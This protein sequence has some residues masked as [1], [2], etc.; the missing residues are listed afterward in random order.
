[1]TQCYLVGGA[2]RDLLLGK[3]PKDFDFAVEASSYEAMRNWLLESGFEI[4]LEAP[5]YFTIRARHSGPWIFADMNLSTHTFDFVLCRREN[6]YSD[7]RHPDSV[8]VGTIYDDLAR[9]D[10]TMNAM[11]IAENGQFIDPYDGKDD[12]EEKLIR[13][14]GD[15][16]R[17]IEDALR[18]FRVI[19]F[20]VVLSFDI[21]DPILDLIESGYPIQFMDNVSVERIREELNKAFTYSSYATLLQLERFSHLQKWVFTETDLWLTPTLKGRRNV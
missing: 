15:T 5:E 18:V 9:R 10:F 3:K 7:G 13:C 1:M 20:A 17:L 8:E 4:F 16:D 21:D 12:I 6:A 19:R 2:V 11:A 14:V